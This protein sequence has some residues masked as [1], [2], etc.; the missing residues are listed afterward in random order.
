MNPVYGYVSD[1]YSN[2]GINGIEPVYDFRKDKQGRTRLVQIDTKDVY[3]EIQT[4][5]DDTNIYS[6]IEKC[7]GIENLSKLDSNKGFFADISDF[8]DNINDY[9]NME[10]ECRYKFSGLPIEIKNKFDNDYNVFMTSLYNGTFDSL[11]NKDVELKN[12]ESEFVNV[13]SYDNNVDI[14]SDNNKSDV[15]EDK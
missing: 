14:K 5:K 1:V 12:I 10:D 11:L 8:P 7:G 3:K 13:K 6:I 9:H 2:S 15:K 4:Y